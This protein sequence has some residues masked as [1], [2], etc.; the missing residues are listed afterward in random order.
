MALILRGMGLKEAYAIVGGYESWQA[1]N[2][3]II[4]G[5]IKKG[6]KAVPR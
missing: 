5:K 1:G 3:P 4:T 2:Y 6:S